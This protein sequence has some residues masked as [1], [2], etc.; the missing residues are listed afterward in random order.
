MEELELDETR[1]HAFCEAMAGAWGGSVRLRVVKGTRINH[2]DSPS[3]SAF[4]PTP[5][6][7][8]YRDNPF[9]SF[10]HC[11][12]V[13]HMVFLVLLRAKAL[14]TVSRVCAQVRG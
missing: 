4:F 5:R 6:A 2:P 12:C 1:L 14:E 11:F 10:R 3:L 9:H 7:D 8:G 13:S